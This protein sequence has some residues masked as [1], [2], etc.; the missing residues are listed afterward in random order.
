LSAVEPRSDPALGALVPDRHVFDPEQPLDPDMIVADLVPAE[1][2]RNGA[3]ARLIG[4]ALG[5]VALAALA[6]AWRFTPLREWLAFDRLVE[7]GIGLREEAWAPV[8]VMLTFI[9]G[10][11]VA[12]PLLVLIA[13]TAL[14][15]GPWL[16]PL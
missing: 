10:G 11:L 16:G 12:F 1:Q 5:V 14:V 8:A 3:R 13:A 7:F 4:V 9:G 2:A 6:L 15:F